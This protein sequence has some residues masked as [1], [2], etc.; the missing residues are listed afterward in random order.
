MK[1]WGAVGGGG[2]TRP[3][4][5]QKKRVQEQLELRSGSRTAKQRFSHRWEEDMMEVGT[6]EPL[7][8]GR[9]AVCGNLCNASFTCYLGTRRNRGHLGPAEVQTSSETTETKLSVSP[10]SF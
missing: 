1:E 10:Q 6:V 7:D 3:P 5:T 4:T 8:T 2:A 9:G